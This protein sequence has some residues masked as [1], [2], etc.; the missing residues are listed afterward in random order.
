MPGVLLPDDMSTEK[1][2]EKLTSGTQAGFDRRVK[3]L[4]PDTETL[5]KQKDDASKKE[6]IGKLGED[7]I[8]AGKTL[9]VNSKQLTETV[10]LM[11]V[12]LTKFNTGLEVVTDKI[13]SMLQDAGM[14]KDYIDALMNPSTTDTLEQQR[15]NAPANKVLRKSGGSGFGL[16][17]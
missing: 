7:V 6:D 5:A 10:D 2:Y 17:S 14:K 9:S 13:K 16:G 1:L 12:H 4:G 11:N 8:T 3:D 15:K